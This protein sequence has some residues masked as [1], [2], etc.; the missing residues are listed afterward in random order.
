[1][2]FRTC[3]LRS[4]LDECIGDTALIEIM[5]LRRR[6]FHQLRFAALA[7]EEVSRGELRAKAARAD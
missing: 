3:A 1:M 5:R 4:I 6:A 7:H 2:T